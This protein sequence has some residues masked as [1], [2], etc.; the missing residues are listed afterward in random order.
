VDT[1]AYISLLSNDQPLNK[2]QLDH[3][4]VIIKEYPYFQNAR[5]LW[6][7]GLKTHNSSLYND[8][9]KTTAVYTTNRDILF[10]YI[11]SEK[12]NQNEVSQTI[13]QQS[14]SIKELDVI[15]EIVSKKT[16]TLT[17]SRADKK[18]TTKAAQVFNPNLFERKPK[19]KEQNLETTKELVTKKNDKED[20]SLSPSKTGTHSFSEWIQLTK[21]EG[22]K[23]TP[24]ETRNNISEESLI[25]SDKNRNFKLIEKFIQDRPKMKPSASVGK[26]KNLAKPFTKEPSK[27][28]TETL[29][30]VYLQQKAY[31]KAIQA[32]KILI[33]KNPEKSG[34]FADQIRAIQKL[35]KQEQ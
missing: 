21:K 15:S 12:F 31:K 6:L 25:D 16:D 18:E 30:K 1:K 17:K 22:P 8:A 5:A 24:K 3:L 27:L 11:T 33:L 23:P 28:M 7:K 35:I 32:Y 2:D 13:F 26:N 14:E 4:A 19:H 10:D 9:L 20:S 34:F 29:A